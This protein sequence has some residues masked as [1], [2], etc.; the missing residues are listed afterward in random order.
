[1]FPYQVICHS[2]ISVHVA[3]SKNDQLRS[4]RDVLLASSKSELCP[5][6]LLLRCVQKAGLTQGIFFFFNLFVSTALL[7]IF[8]DIPTKKQLPYWFS[9]IRGAQSFI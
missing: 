5:V 1:M 3:R 4:G 2:Y 6:T 7:A 9:Q 8:I